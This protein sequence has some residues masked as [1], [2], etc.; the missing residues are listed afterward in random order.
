MSKL[1][2]AYTREFLD[3]VD[4]ALLRCSADS[5]QTT[6][7][8]RRRG[9]LDIRVKLDLIPPTTDNTPIIYEEQP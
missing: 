3:A 6:L 2:K 4:E 8:Y 9:H 7:I 1:S 5:K